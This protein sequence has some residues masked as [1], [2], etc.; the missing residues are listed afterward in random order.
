[1][2][3]WALR[4]RGWELQKGNKIAVIISVASF[5]RYIIIISLL[6]E[7]PHRKTLALNKCLI[8]FFEERR[9]FPGSFFCKLNK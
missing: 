1:M 4:K 6:N 9:D 2:L 8:R 5:I 7:E 3:I